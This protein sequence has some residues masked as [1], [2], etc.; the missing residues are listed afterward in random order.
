ME[1]K[2]VIIGSGFAGMW[3]ALAA[4]RLIELN[5]GVNAGITVTVVAP[6]PRLVLRPRLYEANPGSMSAPLSDLF[7]VAGIEYIQ[8]KV[9]T[10]R[11]PRHEIEVADS[12]GALS[13]IPYDRLILASGS[14]L[15]QPNIPGL[16][17]HAFNIDQ[18]EDADRLENHLR[19][20]GSLPPSPARN[21]VV[22]AGGGFTGIELATELPARLR[23]ILGLDS[24]VRVVV[25]EKA[26]EIGP[27]LGPNPRP[28]ITKALTNLGV[29]TKLGQGVAS[30][31]AGGITATDGSRI[32]ALTVIW[33]AGMQASALTRQI[34][35][36]K[37][38][39][40]RLR[41]D[42][43]LRVPTCK[44]VFATGDT[45]LAACD[46]DGHHAMMS[47]QHA[48]QL[49][50]SAGHNAAADLLGVAAMPY[51]QATYGTCLDL[52]PWG[53][54]VSAGWE[55]NVQISGEQAKPLKQYI[56]RTLIYPPRATKEEALAVADPGLPSPSLRSALEHIEA[57]T[58]A[59]K[60]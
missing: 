18:I 46:D 49:G 1:Q 47:C 38:A 57:M 25:V 11:A 50:R 17:E 5:G 39:F 54:M 20:L 19:G 12:K 40:G 33:T 59:A 16:R 48:I 41:V 23:A 30:I 24:N 28:F 22:V 58:I 35:G 42:Q 43:Y 26:A 37:D 27:E 55:R 6:E 52:G 13:T 44:E 21:T 31:D 2:I 14:V 4:R 56:N 29:E 15:R 36:D 9:E 45:A 32:E 34:E 53:S 51:S 60:A 7:N 8:G 3:S 10:I